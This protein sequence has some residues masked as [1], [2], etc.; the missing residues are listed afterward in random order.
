MKFKNN[1]IKLLLVHFVLVSI[2]AFGVSLC[3]NNRKK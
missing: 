1:K 3:H 2:V